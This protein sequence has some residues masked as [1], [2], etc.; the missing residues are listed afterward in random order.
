[1]YFLL[2]NRGLHELTPLELFAVNNALFLYIS[3]PIEEFMPL[4]EGLL[5]KD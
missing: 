1:M 3:K 2:K 5:F 4:C